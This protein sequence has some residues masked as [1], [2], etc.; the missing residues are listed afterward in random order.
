MARDRGEPDGASL[1]G[2]D[3]PGGGGGWLF[4]QLLG[5]TAVSDSRFARLVNDRASDRHRVALGLHR[6]TVGHWRRGVRPRDGRVA[7]VAAE[8]LSALV[9]YELSPADLG[10]RAGG[11]GVEPDADRAL[12]IAGSP[13][14]TLRVLARLSG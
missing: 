4:A 10:W 1:P 8:Q 13:G 5:E 11:A 12:F 2:A 3:D 14:G 9:G 7:Q 6:T